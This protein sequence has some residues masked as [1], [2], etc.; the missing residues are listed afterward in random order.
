MIS[1]P[2]PEL[3][4]IGPLAIRWYGIFAALGM[5]A[6]FQLQAWRAPKYGFKTEDV[7][8]FTFVTIVSGL[9]GARL[10]YVLRFWNSEFSG[11][12]FLEVFKVYE[13]G[14]VFYGGFIGA[15]LCCILYCRHRKWSLANVADLTAPALPLGHA[16]GRIGCLLNG[17]CFGVPYSGP[18]ATT[19]PPSNVTMNYVQR[20][21]G[22]LPPD[23]NYCASTFPI[24]GIASIFNVFLCLFLLW[25]ERRKKFKGLLFPI[26]MGLYA[27]GRFCIEFG[28]GDSIVKIWGMTPGQRTCACIFPI[29]CIWFIFGYFYQKRKNAKT[30]NK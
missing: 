3:F 8:D 24:E 4:R 11:R 16:L 15:V 13:G 10:A 6:W 9:I 28:R 18:L 17:C 2:N 7:S 19:Y 5:L 25:L 23:A 20:K 29:A 26:Y 21:L 14:L 1:M 12:S 30:G 22:V 27:M